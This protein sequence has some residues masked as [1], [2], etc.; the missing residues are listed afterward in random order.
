LQ[1]DFHFRSKKSEKSKIEKSRFVETGHI[2]WHAA[3][4]PEVLSAWSLQRFVDNRLPY[5]TPKTAWL[6][7]E[8]AIFGDFLNL[9]YYCI[10]AMHVMTSGDPLR[11][12]WHLGSS[13]K[14]HSTGDRTPYKISK[15]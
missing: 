13:N 1:F 12:L 8:N 5:T 2:A 14:A 3:A 6:F 11:L 4:K 7:V 10:L 15:K 9:G